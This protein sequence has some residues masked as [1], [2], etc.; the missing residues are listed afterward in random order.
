VVPGQFEARGHD[1]RADLARFIREV[2][3]LP[4]S[5]AQLAAVE[6]A[7]ASLPIRPQRPMRQRRRRSE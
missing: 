1:Y 3:R 4:A 2:Y 6:R 5:D 7:R